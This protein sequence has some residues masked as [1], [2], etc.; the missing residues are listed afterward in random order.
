MSL[1]FLLPS[2]P[3][4]L[5][6]FRLTP[7]LHLLERKKFVL[8]IPPLL[9]ILVPNFHGH[10]H[11]KLCPKILYFSRFFSRFPLPFLFFPAFPP[12]FLHHFSHT[13]SCLKPLIYRY[14][15]GIYSYILFNL[16]DVP[17]VRILAFS[18]AFFMQKRPKGDQAFT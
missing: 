6:L 15:S 3:Q 9:L 8:P 13:L 16:A 11:K 14:I 18:P 7:F 12:A 1:L 10:R 2:P 5:V 4:T 17:T